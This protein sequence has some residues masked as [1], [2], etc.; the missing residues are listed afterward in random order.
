MSTYL[1][2]DAICFTIKIS[3]EKLLTQIETRIARVTV[4]RDGARVTRTGKAKL[5]PGPHKV[6]V[7]GIT[8]FAREDSFRVKG[9]GPAALS[10]IDVRRVQKIF[11]PEEDLK[12]L[13]DELKKLE[14]RQTE[15]EDE[16]E[17]YNNRLT[18]VDSMMGE[19][20]GV[21]GQAFAADE[22]KIKQLT[23]MDKKSTTLK[24]ETFEK[25]QSLEEELEDIS[26]KINVV[27]ENI[28]KIASKRKTV[29]TYEVDI[30]LE[31]KSESEVELDITYQTSGAYW[32]PSYDV[33]LL[34]GK[35]K[36][37]RVALVSN[38][39][40]EEWEEVG[41][42]ISTAT[43]RPVEAIQGTPFYVHE[44]TPP[45]PKLKKER[46][47]GMR[48][49]AKAAAMPPPAPGGG[50]PPMS[51]P[52]PA[53]MV[54][55]FAEAS[56]SASGISIYV[57]P[58]PMTIPFDYENHP[59]TLTEEDLE[60]KTIHYWYTDEMAE[61][62]AQDEVTNGDNV[63]LPGKVKIYAQGDFVGET[64]IE[65]ISPRE[66]FKLGTR[67][68]YDVKAKKQLVEKEIEK[69]GITRGKLRR[70]YKYR[71][72]IES[73]SKQPVEIEIVDRIPHSN[74][75]SIEVKIDWEKLDLK[76]H[77]LGVM[78]W[79]KNIEPSKKLE[80]LYDFEVLWEKGVTINPP[81]P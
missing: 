26:D 65:Q 18:Q 11:E 14:Q 40:Q 53:P 33:D 12:H 48:M 54:E 36:L 9:K 67:I 69:A 81:L 4:F 42:T 28:G 68:A 19:F 60:S 15:I 5:A 31:V 55:V 78:E 34:V 7:A 45:R 51:A 10:T 75:T 24:E 63:I 23:D 20:V 13:Y 50:G 30:S 52:E 66:K 2:S 6:V 73:F 27:R 39:T 32:S 16:L 46:A 25:I 17:I 43:A 21:F 76:K 59:V 44:Y 71:L 72:E 37:R 1:R 61:V 64:S 70:F 56:E 41:L 3:G 58:D 29:V 8:N 38:Q 35:A 80:I 79:K 62:V 49:M 77:E 57:L 47:R 74:S 22:V